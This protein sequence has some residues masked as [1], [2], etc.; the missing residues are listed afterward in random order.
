MQLDHII[1]ATTTPKKDAE[2]IASWSG[3][4][5]VAGGVHAG[6]GT[7]N[8]LVGLADATCYVEIL[9][10]DPAQ[11]HENNLASPL[12]RLTKAGLYHW[13][14]RHS[15]LAEIETKAIQY[16]LKTSGIIP[17]SR[18]KPDGSLL[19]WQML[20]LH[21]HGLGRWCRF[22]S[23]GVIAPIRR[24]PYRP[25]ALFHILRFKPRMCKPCKNCFKPSA[26][27]FRSWRPT[28]M[29]LPLKS[30]ATKRKFFY[31]W[32]RLLAMAYL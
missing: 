24:L 14:V 9:Y 20:F 12:T 17:L 29:V 3:V 19:R 8:D 31:R 15:N 22:L 30:R 26:W 23:I 2:W 32:H 16:G 18:R 11:S 13:A 6:L 1:W 10:P 28:K 21:R 4:R 7:R 27:R 5:P 25:V